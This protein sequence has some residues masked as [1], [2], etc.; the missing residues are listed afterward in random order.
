MVRSFSE[1]R[2]L[3]DQK[4]LVETHG[5]AWFEVSLKVLSVE[6]TFGIGLPEGYRGGSTLIAEVS[7]VGNPSFSCESEIR[8]PSSA[9]SGTYKAGHE[10]VMRV[11]V[12]GWNSIRKRVILAS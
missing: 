3:S 2:L 1:A 5:G 6:K 4:R 8:L 11:S 7:P 12:Q 10:G 9:D